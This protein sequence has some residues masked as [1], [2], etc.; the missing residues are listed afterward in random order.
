MM[1]VPAMKKP[2]TAPASINALLGQIDER[3]DQIEALRAE[4]AA[5]E[6]APRPLGDVMA[7]I[8]D[9]LDFLATASVDAL[10]LHGLR[11]RG[12]AVELKASA[13]VTLGLLVAVAREPLRQILADQLRDL[14]AARPGLAEKDRLARLAEIDAQILRAEMSEESATR[15]LERL[16]VMI[17]RRADL[18]P[19][20][21]LAADAALAS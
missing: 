8:D 5:I 2:A 11:A 1:R 15:Q 10:A 19:L 18:S 3:R 6:N 14:E 12:A 16:G 7:A 13:G 4:R 21:A 20:V 9:H 17:A